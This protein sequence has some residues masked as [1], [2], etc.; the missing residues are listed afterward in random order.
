VWL[1][2]PETAASRGMAD[3]GRMLDSYLSLLRSRSFCRCMF[4]GALT[5]ASFHTYPTASLFIFT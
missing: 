3:S 4:G 1:V 5:S 2:S